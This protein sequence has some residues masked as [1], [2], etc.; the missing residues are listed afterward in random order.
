MFGYGGH[1][2]GQS[3]SSDTTLKKGSPKDPHIYVSR[4]LAKQF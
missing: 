2:D 1:L 4:E 3:R